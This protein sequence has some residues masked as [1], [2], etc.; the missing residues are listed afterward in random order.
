MR[1]LS[2]RR[3]QLNTSPHSLFTVYRSL[4][5]LRSSLPTVYRLLFTAYCS[6]FTTHRSLLTT[7]CIL[8]TV[9]CPLFTAHAAPYPATVLSNSSLTVRVYLPDATN[10]YYRGSRFDGSGMIAQVDYKGH[11]FF[12]ELKGPH[13]PKVDDHGCGPCEE[14][15]MREPLGFREAAPGGAFIKIGVGRLVKTGANYFFNGGYRIAE[16]GE[17]KIRREGPGR[18]RFEQTLSD[19]NGWGYQYTKELILTDEPAVLRIARTLRNTGTRRIV[20]DHYSHNMFIFDRVP[21]GKAYRLVLPF[22]PE[23]T[24]AP[25]GATT[26][27]GNVIEFGQDPLT[28]TFWTALTGFSTPAHNG[29]RVETPGLGLALEIKTDLAPSKYEVYA[30]QAALCP[31]PFVALDVEPGASLTWTTE[32]RFSAAAVKETKH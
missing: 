9:H 21:I 19:T 6:L 29:V 27:R 23:A 30:E 24:P 10:G 20:T 26:L 11:T 13:N 14:F 18:L 2:S 17:W 4:F 12:G 32:L 31:E 15:G 8:F 5:T 28:S 16:P 22:A 1:L 3:T 25:S 7:Y